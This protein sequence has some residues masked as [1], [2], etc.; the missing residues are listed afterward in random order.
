MNMKSLYRVVVTYMFLHDH[1]HFN[2]NTSLG[3]H[4][5]KMKT[6]SERTYNFIR[7]MIFVKPSK[8]KHT[9]VK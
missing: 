1:K 5:Q 3:A 8:Y 9:V 4:D 6:K 7:D 2:K